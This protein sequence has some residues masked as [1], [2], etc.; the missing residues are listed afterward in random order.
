MKNNTKNSLNR[1][2]INEKTKEMKLEFL[3]EVR[4]K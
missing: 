1:E 3:N 2:K 4:K